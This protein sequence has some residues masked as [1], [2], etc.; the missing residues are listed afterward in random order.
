MSSEIELVGRI[1]LGLMILWLSWNL[2]RL[3]G[4]DL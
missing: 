3:F 2:L 1:V 4:G